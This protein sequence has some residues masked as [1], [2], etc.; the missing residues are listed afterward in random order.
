MEFC[1]LT[2]GTRQTEAL[3]WPY[4]R[5]T[6]KSIQIRPNVFIYLVRCSWSPK[7]SSTRTKSER[8]IYDDL[9]FVLEAAMRMRP[10]AACLNAWQE[11]SSILP[12][13]KHQKLTTPKPY[14]SYGFLGCRQVSFCSA[15]K[16]QMSLQL[17]TISPH[18]RLQ[19]LPI[20][21]P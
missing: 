12:N 20:V 18:V 7:M 21:A 10:M 9:N 17:L 1:P 19:V 16:V 8:A 4:G 6:N 2:L 11:E 15:A 5:A 13:A 3:L 14:N